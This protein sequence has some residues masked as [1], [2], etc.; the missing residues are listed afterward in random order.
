MDQGFSG[1]M[2]IIEDINI[3][4]ET[5][6]M[7]TDGSLIAAHIITLKM[8]NKEEVV[9]SMSKDK[10]QSLFFLLGKILMA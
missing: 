1:F 8:T 3:T 10:L 5:S 7:T 4:G 2:P 6:L 9:C